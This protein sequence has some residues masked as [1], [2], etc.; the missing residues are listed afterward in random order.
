[1]EWILVFPLIPM[2]YQDFKSRN[3]A[4]WQLVLFGIMQ[5]IVCFF[6]YGAVQTGYIALIN[7]I[8]LAS[9]S[10]VML[11][12]AYFRFKLKQQLVGSG[13]IIFIL[14]LTPYFLFPYLLY[15]LIASFLVSLLSWWFEGYLRKIRKY[16]I[17]LVSYLGICYTIVVIYNSLP[18]L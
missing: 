14:L 7:L 1:M 10:I 9:I 18:C 17:P 16:D 15:F 3:V 6:K 4:L 5:I 13:D 8:I 12:Y 2:I 11:V